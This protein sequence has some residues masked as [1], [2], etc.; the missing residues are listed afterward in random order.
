M[1]KIVLLLVLS[2]VLVGSSSSETIDKMMRQE[3]VNSTVSSDR[4]PPQIGHGVKDEKGRKS[5]PLALF[6]SAAVPGAGEYYLGSKGNSKVFFG[7]ELATWAS[8]MAFTYH[9][10]RVR[11]SYK[12]LAGAN[13]GANMSMGSE[14]YW[15]AVEWSR[16]NEEYN[17]RVREDAR[18]LYPGDKQKQQSYIEKHSYTGSQG[19]SWGDIGAVHEFRRLRKESKDAF[20]FAIYATGF[21]LLNRLASVMDVIMISRSEEKKFP[22]GKRVQLVIEPEYDVSGFRVGLLVKG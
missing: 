2:L 4:Y 7:I 19:W 22:K 13:A 10:R 16:T 18:A 8:Y 20:Q 17:G 14:E 12:L 6:M 9:G 21:A 3:L 11:D 1:K 15:N 5:G